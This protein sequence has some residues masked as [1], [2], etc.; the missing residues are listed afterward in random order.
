MEDER[1]RMIYKRDK[2]KSRLNVIGED[3]VKNNRNKAKLIINNKKCYLKEFIQIN[4]FQKE[5]IK[6]YMIL[7]RDICNLSYMFKNCESLLDL[8]IYDNIE[9]KEYIF[10]NEFL[11]FLVTT[12]EIDEKENLL[13]DIEIDEEEDTHPIFKNLEE[14]TNIYCSEISNKEDI[15]SNS[16][17]QTILN[18][19][20]NYKIF[21][22]NNYIILKGIFYNCKSL[23]SLSNISKLNTTNSI[24]MSELFYNCSSLTSLPN[25]SL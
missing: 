8:S 2:N 25:I 21:Q 18:N 12:K 4:N 6:I 7:S 9:N 3:F 10:E 5:N 15:N 13:Y 24:D 20:E 23:K 11:E 16:H 14:S 1:F 19:F 17:I 22:Q